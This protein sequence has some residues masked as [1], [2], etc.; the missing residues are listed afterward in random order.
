MTELPI[1]WWGRVV[2]EVNPPKWLRSTMGTVLSSWWVC[3]QKLVCFNQ[4]HFQAIPVMDPE[5]GQETYMIIDPQVHTLPVHSI[6]F[7]FWHINISYCQGLIPSKKC[8]NSKTCFSQTA[9]SIAEGGGGQ[10]FI[11]M[12]GGGGVQVGTK[13]MLKKWL[14][15]NEEDGSD[16]VV[17]TGDGERA[18]CSWGAA[19]DGKQ[20]TIRPTP[21]LAGPV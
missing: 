2:K 9:Q 1:W 3:S 14:G 10:Q 13:E 18:S 7:Y 8:P 21:T 17:P 15:F 12:Q 16:E 20:S 6:V 19:A 4:W 11:M 5:T